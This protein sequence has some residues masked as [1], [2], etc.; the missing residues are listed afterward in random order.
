ML[1][2]VEGDDAGCINKV[3]CVKGEELS[4]EVSRGDGEARIPPAVAPR[5]VGSLG[6]YRRCC[7]WSSANR[8]GSCCRWMAVERWLNPD[9]R[10][11]ALVDNMSNRD[12][13]KSPPAPPR[14]G[15]NMCGPN[16][17]GL[18]S[19]G[20]RSEEKVLSPTERLAIG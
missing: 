17:I 7:W 18:P 11:S 13:S 3:R 19:G 14:T 9:A 8:K 4:S 10:A 16:S 15:E 6:E 20:D 5:K 1:A 12:W 2:E